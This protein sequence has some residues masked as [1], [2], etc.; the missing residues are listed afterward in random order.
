MQLAAVGRLISKPLLQCYTCFSWSGIGEHARPTGPLHG[1]PFWLSRTRHKAAAT[2]PGAGVTEKSP[3][4]GFVGVLNLD[5]GRTASLNAIMRPH[6]ACGGTV[7]ECVVS[8]L[9][10]EIRDILVF[11]LGCEEERLTDAARLTADLGADSLDIVE[12]MMSCEER[13][14][15]D[16]PNQVA[17]RLVTVGDTVEWITAYIAMSAD[18]G[19]ARQP[20]SLGL[21]QTL[22]RYFGPRKLAGT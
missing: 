7:R 1:G 17:S 6:W 13:F 11:H 20:F 8:D 16:I 2:R 15:I 9:A 18:T 22:W 21:G 12:I 3:L 5:T 4:Q 19:P 10:D 14:C